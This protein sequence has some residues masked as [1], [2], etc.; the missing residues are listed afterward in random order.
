MYNKLLEIY[1]DQLINEPTTF[2]NEYYYFYGSDGKVF[3]ISKNIGPNEYLLLKS[4]FLE[5]Q[6][7]YLDVKQESIYKYIYENGHYPFKKRRCFLVLEA[8]DNN[9]LFELLDDVLLDLEVIRINNYDV[10]FYLDDEL[11]NIKEIFNTI[12]D[13]FGIMYN[14]HEGLTINAQIPGNFI[15]Y[16]LAC[17]KE[18]NILKKGYSNISDLVFSKDN[19]Q[20]M[21]LLTEMKKYLIDPVL[22]KN[23]NRETLNAFFNNDLNV[24]KTAKVL[25]LNRNSLINRLDIISKELGMDVQNFKNAALLLLLFK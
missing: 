2:T 10:V 4:M 19:K 24:S 11:V 23:N 13:D 12:S 16:Y 5:K 1:S 15:A 9:S 21:P 18:T 25:Y 3:G 20:I 7:L 22:N 6:V 17:I 14:V 8:K